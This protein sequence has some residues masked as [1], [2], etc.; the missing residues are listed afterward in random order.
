MI[1]FQLLTGERPFRGNARMLVHQV[2]NDEPPSPRKLNANVSR[3]L[4]TITLKCLEKE[5]AKRYQTAE[6]VAEELRRYLAGEPIQARPIGRVA[7]LW[8][9]SRRNPAV[10]GLS[11]ALVLLLVSVTLASMMAAGRLMV[12]AHEREKAQ[13]IAEYERAN[14]LS[15]LKHAEDVAALNR[16]QLYASR[17][18][19][20][21]QA[22]R[23]GDLSR[24]MKLLGSLRPENAQADLRGFEWHYLWRLCHSEKRVLLGHGK[25]V[26]TV[27]FSPD[28]GIVAAGGN[29]KVVRLWDAA[30]GT[31]LPNSFR[32]S[33][34]ITAVVFSPRDS[35]LALAGVDKEVVLWDYKTN[36]VLSTLTGHALGTSSL[37]FSP[38][39]NTLATAAGVLRVAGG[40]PLTRFVR[41]TERGDVTLWDLRTG[42]ATTTFEAHQG[43]VL[44]LAFSP[45]GSKLVTGGVD[46]VAKIWFVTQSGENLTMTLDLGHPAIGVAFSPDGRNIA[47]G[48]WS[49]F[50]RI[51]DADTGSRLVVVDA[52]IGPITCV[53]YSPDGRSLVTTG[54]DQLVRLWD[55]ASG[56]ATST[57]RGHTDAVW[58]A[59]FS[60]DGATLATVTRDGAVKLWNLTREQQF[61]GLFNANRNDPPMNYTVAFSPDGKLLA[62]SGQ[63]VEIWDFVA[64]V[65]LRTL[66]NYRDGDICVAFSPDGKTL[67]AAGSSGVLR[68]WVTDTW[69]LAAKL[70]GHPGKIWSLEFSPDGRLLATG[71]EEGIIKL[72]DINSRKE[73]LT[74]EVEERRV[75]SVRF[76][77]DGLRLAASCFSD[78]EAP[79]RKPS[80]IRQWD[81]E[82]GQELAPFAKAGTDLVAFS[83]DG[84]FAASGDSRIVRLWQT[85][86]PRLVRAMPGHMDLIYNGTFSPD[87]KTLATAS[88]DGTARLWHVA[89]GQELLVLKGDT[90]MPV[91]CVAFAPDSSAL[92]MGSGYMQRDNPVGEIAIYCADKSLSHI[93]QAVL[94]S[95]GIKLTDTE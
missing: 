49:G 71:G 83:A 48:D 9:W 41:Q 5:P 63:V 95:N 2:L 21:Y 51:W 3:D 56:E 53:R 1:L 91:W 29:D 81:V 34:N 42:R 61:D 12:L 15:S 70:T 13:A 72:W 65:K 31:E 45:D 40:T 7:K 86:P 30:S 23:E 57:I 79:K 46:R 22:W 24:S 73:Q 84:K 76:T 74:I 52:H 26:R 4:E 88:W 92:V 39:G 69:K 43:D 32:H 78:W 19:V 85:D 68:L 18:N 47:T 90:G 58:A 27:A 44:S 77:P 87:G 38:D 82:T 94:G 60:P 11:A 6:E 16:Q 10:A 20:A 64:G 67:A 8:R 17:I 25:A 50:L 80:Y 62:T 28:G 75:C 54:H 33:G 89:T 93:G 66:E 59:A 55:A 35:V 37:A 14:A 36:Q